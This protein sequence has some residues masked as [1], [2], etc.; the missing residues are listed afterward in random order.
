VDFDAPIVEVDALHLDLTFDLQNRI[1][2]SLLASEF[3]VSF[4]KIIQGVHE[5]SW[6]NNI[7][8]DERTNKRDNETVRKHNAFANTVE[9]DRRHGNDDTESTLTI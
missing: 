5:I 9:I 2:S 1:W 8:P 7:C 4:I 3:P 6:Y